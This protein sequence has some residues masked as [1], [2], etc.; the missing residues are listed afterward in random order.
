M[1]WIIMS[2]IPVYESVERMCPVIVV[3]ETTSAVQA[4]ILY[5]PFVNVL[6][7]LFDQLK[8]HWK[9]SV[10]K[11]VLVWDSSSQNRIRLQSYPT[12]FYGIA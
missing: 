1:L 2:L 6:F 3:Y 7:E 5:I 10:Y 12:V 4:Y 8:I 9:I 11:K